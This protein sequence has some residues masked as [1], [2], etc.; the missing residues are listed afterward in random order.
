MNCKKCGNKFEPSKG[1]MNY[2]SMSCRNSRERS[3]EVKEKIRQSVKNGLLS[4]KIPTYQERIDRMTE[5]QKDQFFSKLKEIAE[6]KKENA[7]NEIMSVPFESLS[8]E[9]LRK[10]VIYEQN[11]RCNVCGISEWVGKPISLELEHKDGNHHNNTRTN[12]E[13]LC[14]NCH[15]QTATFRGRNKQS[16]R[17][18]VSD[19]ELLK[20]MV[21]NN[22]NIRQSLIEVGMT[23]KGGNYKRCYKLKKLY[24]SE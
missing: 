4:G 3:D 8:F 11:E 16:N 23:P 14:P 9:R 20:S 10:R 13:A 12:L 7:I 1:L 6:T 5:K 15:S 21:S 24:L 19:E 22:F 17:L 18:L 2:C